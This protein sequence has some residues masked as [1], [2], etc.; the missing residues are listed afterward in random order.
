[1]GRIRDFETCD[2]IL[3][4]LDIGSKPRGYVLVL[5]FNQVDTS[6]IH[7]ITTPRP[8]QTKHC[9]VVAAHE[10]LLAGLNKTLL[11]SVAFVVSGHVLQQFSR[12]VVHTLSSKL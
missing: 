11:L 3:L 7:F 2:V 9:E 12:V 5:G 8:R 6:I 4:S 10:T 1:M